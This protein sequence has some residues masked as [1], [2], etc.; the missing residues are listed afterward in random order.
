MGVWAAI[1]GK[2]EGV[3][4]G[5]AELSPKLYHKPLERVDLAAWSVSVIDD[6]FG[7]SDLLLALALEGMCRV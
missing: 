4:Q 5:L 2:P 3:D 7:M 1:S 6:H